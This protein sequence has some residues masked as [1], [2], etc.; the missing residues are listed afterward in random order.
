MPGGMRTLMR[1]APRKYDPAL[2]EALAMNGALNPK[3]DDAGRKKA[4]ATVA[5][6]LGRAATWKRNGRGEV[7]AEGGYLLRRLWR[8]V[9]DAHIVEK[10]FL[11]SAEARKLA[12]ARAPS[13]PR[14]TPRRRRSKR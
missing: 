1:Y 2:I 12:H 5:A 9:T 3:L 7:A 4:I 8:G 11:V 14:S 10:S 13:R 6:W